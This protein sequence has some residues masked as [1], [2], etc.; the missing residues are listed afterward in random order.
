[1]LYLPPQMVFNIS[2]MNSTLSS[3]EYDAAK[4]PLGKLAKS[5]L[6]QGYTALKDLSELINDPTLA[7]TK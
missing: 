7:S 2:A 1:V 6:E 4:L 5:T 3:F